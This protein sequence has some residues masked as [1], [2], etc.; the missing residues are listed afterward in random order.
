ML[1]YERSGPTVSTP[2]LLLHAGIADRRMWDSIWPTLTAA[3]DV[4]RVD[5]RGFGGST[6]RPEV[7][8][9]TGPTSWRP[10]TPSASNARTSSAAPSAPG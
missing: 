3:R 8:G 6:E 10:S 1:S 2:I 7:R 5:L 4:V 9:R